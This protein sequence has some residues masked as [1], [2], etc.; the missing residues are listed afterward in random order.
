MMSSLSS[1]FGA[2]YDTPHDMG[3][4]GAYM[5]P[6]VHAHPQHMMQPQSYKTGMQMP[7]PSVY[8]ALESN[9]MSNSFFSSFLTSDFPIDISFPVQTVPEAVP[10]MKAGY[11]PR[12]QAQAPIMQ[13]VAAAQ[14]AAPAAVAPVATTVE[15]VKKKKAPS[16]KTAAPSAKAATKSTKRK[17]TAPPP[18]IETDDEDE[19]D[20]LDSPAPSSRKKATPDVEAKRQKRRVK[21]REAAQLFRQRQKQH[22]RDLEQQ[23]S[24]I[25]DKNVD[26]ATQME[27][28]RAENTLVKD[29]LK[30]LRN[31]VVEGLRSAYPE[32]KFRE[33]EALVDGVAVHAR[34]TPQL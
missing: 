5:H 15:V 7:D 3:K 26:L 14:Q 12:V 30:F 18:P 27:V 9:S 20:E 21:N 25:N 19:E 8:D 13:V 2:Y 32:Q 29:Q 4:A 6:H 10:L 31:F 34:S 23:V 16:R 1:D 22:I 17:A 11:V 33:M 24:N 28:L